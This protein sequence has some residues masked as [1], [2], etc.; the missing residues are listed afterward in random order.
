MPSC[1]PP[2]GI[3]LGTTRSVIATLAGEK[4][5]AIPNR[6]GECTTPSIVAFSRSGRP[7]VGR[8]A[9]R[10][11]TTNPDATVAAVK[12]LLGTEAL[13]SVA[14]RRYKPQEIAGLI[15]RQ[16]K[17][18][19]EQFL[20]EPIDEAVITVPA[21]FNDRQRRAVREAALLA[22]LSVPML[23][24]EPTAAALAYGLDR[25]ESGTVLVWDLGGGT[26]DVSV[27]ELGEGVF[28]VLAVSGDS[29]LG[30]L[31]FDA[32]IAAHLADEF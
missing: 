31:D 23:L 15:L 26:F 8:A 24:N 11:A 7:L 4:P 30:G 21:Y 5:V 1:S 25:E 19:A 10:Q 12:R 13:I 22:E 32:A 17:Q 9:Q 2:I 14:G 3:D 18:D 16:L 29:S 20:H 28:E 27:L 6:E